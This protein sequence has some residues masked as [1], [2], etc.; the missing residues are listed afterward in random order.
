[1]MK[2]KHAIHLKS[3]KGENTMH[4]NK[5][6][7]AA[8]C[9]ASIIYAKRD[10]LPPLHLENIVS[11]PVQ[12]F[13][14]NNQNSKPKIIVDKHSRN[15]LGRKNGSKNQPKNYVILPEETLEVDVAFLDE[16]KPIHN[17]FGRYEMIDKIP[18]YWYDGKKVSENDF[19][20]LTE[21][22]LD[23]SYKEFGFRA[24]LTASEINELISGPRKVFIQEAY[25]YIEN[26]AVD[27]SVIFSLSEIDIA[28]NNS[29]KGYGVGIYVDEIG[30]PES[31]N[32]TSNFY[33]VGGC[34]V[35]E[36]YHPTGVVTILQ[37]T[38]PD[39]TVFGYD[40]LN[41]IPYPFGTLPW[42]S[43]GNH[44]WSHSTDSVYS[45]TDKRFD[46]D[47]YN[48]RVAHFFA[49]GNQTLYNGNFSVLA[50]ATAFNV[51]SVGAISPTNGAYGFYSRWGN[52]SMGN[53]KPEVGNYGEFIFPNVY[54]FTD[55]DNHTWSGTFSQT[56]AATPYTAGMAAVLM[57]NI[58]IL[59]WHPELLKAV[60]MAS[61]KN[62]IANAN[63]HDQDNITVA[64]KGIS[65]FSSLSGTRMNF[66]E[67][68]NSCCF[69]SNNKISFTETNIHSNTHYRA[70]I[71]WLTSG[72]YIANNHSIAQDLDLRIYQNGKLVAH[73]IS[74]DNSFEVVFTTTSNADLT[75]EILRHANSGSDN[76]IL[77]YSFWE[78]N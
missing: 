26:Y 19:I 23:T 29:I 47:V 22:N 16:N 56:S 63:T 8:M 70:A 50:P 27:Y 11:E 68:I 51:I 78:D 75:I 55:I 49:A 72:N 18:S 33:Q 67:G 2:S 1:M 66:W 77:G 13:L 4:S 36:K 28:H 5:I 32:Y 52:S 58:S 69:D 14:E 31:H 6:V 42:I 21:S 53:D 59:K 73:S 60:F 64:A 71:S 44:S 34:T 62:S 37:K 65:T 54:T 24:K 74:I 39:A 43:I 76:V 40:Q 57:S 12:R 45:P 25:E 7:L 30:C 41:V 15:V 48:N 17:H 10:Y 20:T 35:G 9:L 61:E 46:D 38:A 3:N